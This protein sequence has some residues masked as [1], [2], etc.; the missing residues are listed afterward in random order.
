MMNSREVKEFIRE[1][2]GLE[3]NFNNGV[4]LLTKTV[5]QRTLD[6]FDIWCLHIPKAN[7]SIFMNTLLNDLQTLH[8]CAV[9]GNPGSPCYIGKMAQCKPIGNINIHSYDNCR[10]N[11]QTK[12]KYYYISGKFF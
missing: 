12:S 8:C 3:V 10:L 2:T 9:S 6:I 5:L 11:I 1:N 4:S 7:Y